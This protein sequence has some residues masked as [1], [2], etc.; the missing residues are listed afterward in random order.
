RP[1]PTEVALRR[2]RER[3][4]ALG[5]AEPQRE[6]VDRGR[7]F[8]PLD[9]HAAPRVSGGAPPERPARGRAGPEAPHQRQLVEDEPRGQ[10]VPANPLSAA[11]AEGPPARPLLTERDPA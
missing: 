2:T 5:G 10:K 7:L 1:R 9:R 8:G 3:G 6:A 4:A 11:R